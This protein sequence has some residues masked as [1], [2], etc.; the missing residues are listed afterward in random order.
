MKSTCRDWFTGEL[1]QIK[2]HP[3][4][5]KGEDRLSLSR[6]WKLLIHFLKERKNSFLQGPS[7]FLLNPGCQR[8]KKTSS[9]ALERAFFSQFSS[10]NFSPVR[11]TYGAPPLRYS[12]VLHSW[13]RLSLLTLPF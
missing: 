10:S 11:K 2:L 5:M 4:T 9:E 1:I 6:S 7:Y 3:S 8:G 12:T 13:K